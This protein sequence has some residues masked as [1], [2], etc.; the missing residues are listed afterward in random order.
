M[1]QTDMTV[2][3]NKLLKKFFEG[4]KNC[5]AAVVAKANFFPIK[6]KKHL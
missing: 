5:F 1:W 3:R 4:G 2:N 6:Q